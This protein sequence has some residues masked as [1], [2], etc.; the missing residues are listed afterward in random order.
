MRGC[1]AYRQTGIFVLYCRCNQREVIAKQGK[2]G[3]KFPASPGKE[4][5]TMKK[6]TMKS[7]FA[8]ILA[9]VL[10]FSSCFA[11]SASAAAGV[12]AE[13][14]RQMSR[15][16]GADEIPK[17][18]Y[19]A[20]MEII[21]KFVPEGS[22]IVDVVNFIVDSYQDE[23]PSLIDISG[24]I[25]EL[26]NEM[27]EQFAEIKEQMQQ[28]TEEIENKIVDQT[29]IA[30]KGIGF[31]KLM[32]ALQATDRQLKAI[33]ADDTLNDNEKAV[34]VAALIG[35]NTEWVETDN[36]Y[37]QYQDF[38]NTLASPSFADQKDRD[39]YQVV[40]DDMISRALFSG[41]ALRLSEPYI[42]RVLLLGLYAYTL[43]AECLKAAQ[44]VSEFTAD[45][46]ATLNSDVLYTYRQIKS[47][48][49]I[50]NGE[51]IHIND[52]MFET[53][54]SDT[55]VNHFN[56]YESVNKT[57]FINCGTDNTALSTTLRIGCLADVGDRDALFNI[58]DIMDNYDFSIDR[59]RL[60]AEHVKAAYPDTSLRT[61]LTDIGF[62]MSNVPQDAFVSVDYASAYNT[63]LIVVDTG[64]AT[65]NYCS[66][67]SVSVDDSS[68][69]T[70]NRDCY[71][72]VCLPDGAQYGEVLSEAYVTNFQLA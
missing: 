27:S 69:S 28:Y 45:D 7:A 12:Q 62:D 35:N 64:I 14:A 11:L 59:L 56:K 25:E 57:V 38:M 46:E 17:K 67:P 3:D 48:T 51:I 37:F 24:Q 39:L 41:E 60:V 40:Y 71:K 29:V 31:D 6:F 72:M 22:T 18:A 42:Q 1:F 44:T 36:P 8:I 10:V 16:Q 61:F 21:K 58:L 66:V 63:E 52:K 32:T 49:S 5:S 55:V 26:R 30:G 23:G 9:I 65:R 43:N 47:L 68:V 53:E 50:V 20:G 15:R 54:M 13:N 34:E 33:T 70:I 19:E 2:T 4:N